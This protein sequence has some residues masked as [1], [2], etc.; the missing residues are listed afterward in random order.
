MTHPPPIPVRWSP[1]IPDE[2][3]AALTPVLFR[4]QT[5]L[6]T[7][8]QDFRVGFDTAINQ[9]AETNVNFRNRWVVLNVG[10]VWLRE[11]QESRENA[12]VHE[13]VHVALE[14]LSNAYGRMVEDLTE[15]GTPLRALCDSTFTDALE[16]SVEDLARALIRLRGDPHDQTP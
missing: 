12:I 11:R 15:P 4:W 9:F 2:V 1:V 10:A 13:L 3:Q 6:P 8:V 7:W 5:L 16:G 14:P